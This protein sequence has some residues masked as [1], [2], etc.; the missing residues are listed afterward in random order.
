MPG[1]GDKPVI[2]VRYGLSD[3]ASRAM[4]RFFRGVT[5][6]IG[7]NDVDTE[8]KDDLFIDEINTTPFQFVYFPNRT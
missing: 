4:R 3:I 2:L 8:K 7:E 6:S 1:L 5:K